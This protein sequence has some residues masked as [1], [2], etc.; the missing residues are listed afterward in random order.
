MIPSANPSCIILELRLALY[1][2]VVACAYQETCNECGLRLTLTIDDLEEK[3][4]H[5]VEVVHVAEY[6][7]DPGAEIACA[8]LG[9]MVQ[10][11]FLS[12]PPRLTRFGEQV[13]DE[14]CRDHL[15]PGQLNN[16]L[17]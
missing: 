5:G 4:V 15:Y 12:A 16:N 14:I 1:R 9:E 7:L 17:H 2:R 13:M 10:A 3:I 11:D 8:M 6:G